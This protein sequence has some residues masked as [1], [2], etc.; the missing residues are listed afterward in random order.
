[1]LVDVADARR[2]RSTRVVTIDTGVLF[3]ET[4]RD[5]AGVR[6]A[7]RRAASTSRTPAA[8]WTGPENCCGDAKVAALERAL[9]GRRRR[10]SPAS[11]ASRPP[12]R[13]NARDVEFDEQARRSGST[14]RSPTGPRR[15]LWQRDQRARPALPPA[16]RPA[17]TPRSAARPAP[18]PGTAARAAGR[19][20]TRSSAGFTSH[21]P[22]HP[23]ATS[24]RPRRSTSCARS[25]PSSSA[26]CCCS[27]AARTRSCC[28]AWP[29]R[30]S[31]PARF[32][33]P[34]MHVDTGHNFPEVIEF[35]DRRVAEL[36]ERLIVASVQESI[37]RGRVVEETGPRASRNRLQTTTLLD[38]IAEHGFDAA[39][40]GARRD[41]ERA[42]AK[43][44]IFSFRDDFGQW[45]PKSQRPELW[46]LYNGRIRK[47]RAHP[48][49]PDLQLDRARRLAVHPRG[50]LEIPSIY[51]AHE[52]E[53]FARDG[54]LY[55]DSRASSSCIDGE[56]PFTASVRYRTVGDMSCTG[57][58][59]L[60]GAHARRTSS[61]R[62][63]RRA[64][65]ERGETR[66][67]DRVTEAAMEDRKEV[68]GYFSTARGPPR[69]ACATAGSVDDGKSTLIGR[70]LLRLE[71]GLRGPARA[72]R[73]VERARRRLR[74]PRAADRRPA[75]RA[76][77]GH[78]DRRRLPLLRDAAAQ[79]HHRRHARPRAVHAQHGH[80][81]LDRRP[82]DR[83]RRRAQGRP[84]ADAPPRPHRRAARHPAPR[85]RAS[86]RWTSSTTTRSVFDAIEREFCALRRRARDARADV[87]PDLARCTATTSSTARET[88]PWYAGPPL[89]EH[90]ETVDVAADRNLDDARFPV[91]YV[92]R[93]QPTSTPTTA[94]TPARSPAAC[95]APATRSS[96][97]RPGAHDASPRST[98]STGE[99][100]EAFPPMSVTMRLADEL[101][102]SRGDMIAAAGRPP[103]AR[104]ASSR[105]RLL[106]GRR[107]AARR[108]GATR[109]STRRAPCARVVDARRAPLDVDTLEPE[110][111]AGRAG[112][113][114]DRPRAPAHL[115]RRC[116]ST[117]TRATAPP[118]RSS[119]S[120]R[121][122]TRRSARA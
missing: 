45:D 55:A 74:E 4:L 87:H 76:R 62:S 65:T 27:P 72:R 18:S 15:D 33:F 107:A 88:M 68:Q 19:A 113:Q 50:A 46:N 9:D 115:A 91:Q 48:R 64:I 30:R 1:M 116:A 37:D 66:A 40:G 78:H 29:R 41:E 97:C 7:L 79:V 119:S 84:R 70:L 120:T 21:E 102:V 8:P 10:G 104:R 12:T 54:M 121:R 100:D 99:L 108:A 114:R 82:R 25:P 22:A 73:G 67:D 90:L 23:P 77:A 39:F 26:R 103:D 51:F 85:R 31:G 75:R 101:D 42:R 17:A 38:A 11:A 109:S 13:A 117:P 47:R 93:P 20:W 111:G 112:A 71:A 61:P 35:R 96:C 14:T 92:I 6:G 110:P 86:T 83:A 16:A 43:E 52:R 122:R 69:C 2:R 89:L 56:Q 105:R 49:L 5:V 60:D 24:S 3:P 63:P 118:A 81:R 95:C 44:R 34:L 80:R 53:V 36:G 28:C 94:A 32:P 58:V 59:E 98:P 106:D 57:A